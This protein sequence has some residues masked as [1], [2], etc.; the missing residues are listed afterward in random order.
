LALNSGENRSEARDVPAGM[1][2]A[3]HEA[4][5]DRVGDSG[6]HDRN[7][8]GRLLRG[9]HGWCIDG[10]DHVHPGLHEVARQDREPVVLVLRKPLVDDRILSFDVA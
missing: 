4:G 7:C 6:H 10:K 9:E 2:K 8:P 5:P 3:R 1:R